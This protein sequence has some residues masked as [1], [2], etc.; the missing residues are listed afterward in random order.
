ML[1]G[2]TAAARKFHLQEGMVSVVS[3]A[4]PVF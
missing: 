4:Q 1:G 2:M 3:H